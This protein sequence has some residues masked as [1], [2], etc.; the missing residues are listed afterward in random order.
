MGSGIPRRERRPPLPAAFN[1][2]RDVDRIALR[3]QDLKVVEPD[4]DIEDSFLPPRQVFLEDI[5]NM[6]PS[7]AFPVNID[8][9]SVLPMRPPFLRRVDELPP[10]DGLLSKAMN[11]VG[12]LREGEGLHRGAFVVPL[13]QAIGDRDSSH[14]RKHE[15]HGGT[16]RSGLSLGKRKDREPETYLAFILVWLDA[17]QRGFIEGIPKTMCDIGSDRHLPHDREQRGSTQ[18]THPTRVRRV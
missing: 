10:I 9:E 14:G 4:S 17:E 2:F 6:C 12:E 5:E 3:V 11:Q 7:F 15:R 1:E 18:R 13:P 16:A 8:A